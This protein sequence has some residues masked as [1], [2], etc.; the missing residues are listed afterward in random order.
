MAKS[1]NLYILDP[2]TEIP[3][4]VGVVRE[5]QGGSNELIL[6]GDDIAKSIGNDE[7]GTVSLVSGERF[8]AAIQQ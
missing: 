4:V 3:V 8:H 7:L 5:T 1:E 2:I 6:N